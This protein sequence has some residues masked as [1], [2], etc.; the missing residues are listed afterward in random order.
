MGHVLD[1]CDFFVKH[2]LRFLLL[3]GGSSA[4][5]RNVDLC[6]QQRA[7]KNVKDI[8]HKSKGRPLDD[9]RLS[10]V[11]LIKSQHLQFKFIPETWRAV[12]LSVRYKYH[13]CRTTCSAYWQRSRRGGHVWDGE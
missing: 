8:S 6:D 5:D 1:F 3:R 13:A 12:F 2:V 11:C 9:E 7:D 4:A 10:D